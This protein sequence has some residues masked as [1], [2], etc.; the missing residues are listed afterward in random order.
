MRTAEAAAGTRSYA[1]ERARDELAATLARARVVL[2]GESTHGTHEFYRER[3][4][5]T[6]RLVE[7]HGFDAVAVEG[8]W[9]DCRRVDRW[10]RGATGDGTAAEALSGFS[11]FPTWMWRNADVLDLVGWLR[12]WA[13]EQPERPARLYGLDLYSLHASA[14]AVLRYLDRVDPEAAARARERYACLDHPGGDPLV[15]GKKVA[16]GLSP[17]CE[18]EVIGQLR[19]LLERRAALVRLGDGDAADA[20]FGAEQDARVVQEAERYYRRMFEGAGF[21]GPGGLSGWNLRDR[22][23]ADTLDRIVQHLSRT[24]GH[25]ARVVVW[26]H[27]SHVGDAR[28]TEL[29]DEGEWTLGQLAR[30]RWSDAAVLVGFTT[31][32]GTVTAADSWGGDPRRFTLRPPLR[33]SLE[34]WLSRI[35]A[36]RLWVPREDLPEAELL[37]RAVGVVYRPATERASHHF[38]AR[39]AA[40]YD[41]V[42]HLEVTRAVEPLEGH[43]AL[44][45][46]EPAETWPF[47]V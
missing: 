40:T 45:L 13:E 8:D 39:P 21:E 10:I 22:H 19:E 41:H 6:R 17:S 37:H 28:G 42:V 25:A 32:T 14:E 3:A 38:R 16:F 31:S 7:D 5:L 18:R 11:R 24:R 30:E 23:M 2:L 47:S 4:L 29:G 35:E 9:P 34:S 43:A 33:G 20:H 15:Y 46:E 36:P 44:P 1:S 27:N 26:A 12:A